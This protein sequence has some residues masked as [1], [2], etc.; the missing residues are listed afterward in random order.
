[1]FKFKIAEKGLTL[2]IIHP[3]HN[4]KQQQQDEQ[5]PVQQKVQ[6]L[7]LYPSFSKQDQL[8]VLG[9]NH[10]VTQILINLLSNAIKFTPAGSITVSYDYTIEDTRVVLCFCVRDTGIGMT[11][12]EQA[13]LF[14]PFAQANS[15]IYMKYGGSGLGLKISKEIIEHMGGSIWLESQEGVGT[16]CSFTIVCDKIT[17]DKQIDMLVDSATGKQLPL[18]KQQQQQEQHQQSQHQQPK[19]P[20]VSTLQL[21]EGNPPSS[22][23]QRAPFSSFPVPPGDNYSNN[24]NVSSNGNNNTVPTS[25]STMSTTKRLPKKHVLIVD[26]NIINQKLLKRILEGDGYT[27]DTAMNGK[28]CVDKIYS[29]FGSGGKTYDVVLMDFEMPL[30]NGIEATQKIRKFEEEHHL[31]TPVVII[32]VSANARDTHSQHALAVGM[33]G[34]ITK[35][36]QKKD[37]FAAMDASSGSGDSRSQ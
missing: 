1:M 34:Y 31:A 21:S 13:K 10:R 14:Q 3:S 26:D 33:N 29:M 11:E 19:Q 25:S 24:N 4:N 15:G 18:Q 17:P 36:F 23:R 5:Q 30:M 7:Q 27:T 2:N 16:A 12:Q 9:D 28:E 20:Q 35:P 32:G 8:V 22:K 6:Q 37:V